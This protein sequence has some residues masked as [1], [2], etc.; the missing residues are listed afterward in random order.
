MVKLVKEE[1]SEG[2]GGRIR[3]QNTLVILEAAEQEFA[4]NGY[5]GTSMQAIADRAGLPKANLHYYYKSKGN[6]YGAVLERIIKSWNDGLAHMSEDDDP[7]EVLESYIR[8]KVDLACHYPHRSKLFASE[9]ISGAPAL[10]QYI[11]KDMR[12][13]LREKVRIIQAWI[14]QGKI[15]AVD[16]YHLM[17]MIWATTQHYAD[18]ETQILMLMNRAEYDEDDVE[19][20]CRHLIEVILTGCGLKPSWHS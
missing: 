10:H 2:K 9:I 6:L 12:K 1:V 16:P 20:I 19:Q 18:F 11:R 8:L 17:F 7:A 5:K 4:A 13:F 15:K 3:Q 14:D